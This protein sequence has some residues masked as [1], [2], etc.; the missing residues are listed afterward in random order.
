MKKNT[1][2]LKILQKN[3]AYASLY[4][5]NAL[6]T[7]LESKK[8]QSQKTRDNLL[9][10][11]QT[12]SDYFQKVVMLRNVFCEDQRYARITQEHLKEEFLHNLALMKDRK[13][14]PTKWDPILEATSSWFAW[15]MMTLNEQEKTLLVHFVLE[16]SG[17]IFF[18]KAY[19]VLGKYGET[20]YF[21]IHSEADE[22]H[23][24]MG[25][26]L[27]KN[28]SKDNLPRMLEVLQQGWDV[29]NA[30]C[31]RIAELTK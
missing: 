9:A 2:Y 29:L 11:I 10:C 7:L 12:L 23:E 31:N 18:H 24:K 22:E 6:M 21:K 30:A 26:A 19:K 20:D 4:K 17:N 14:K 5:K 8:L 25:E 27:L 15:K 3:K 16:T 13:N 28:T 1:S